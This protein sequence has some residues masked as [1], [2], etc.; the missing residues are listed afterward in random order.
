[1]LEVGLVFVVGLLYK[2]SLTAS[3]FS[4]DGGQRPI[5]RFMRQ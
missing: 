4:G 2:P 3:I 1:V 5:E